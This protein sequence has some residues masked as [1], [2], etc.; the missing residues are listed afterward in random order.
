MSDV[1]DREVYET[2][3]LGLAAYLK[4]KDV[5]MKTFVRSGKKVVFVFY[6]DCKEK[7]CKKL[8]VEYLNSECK[9][10]D[11]FVRDFKKLFKKGVDHVCVS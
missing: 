10:F 7:D 6:D 9:K 11:S 3:I 4:M 8:Y 2:D 1:K 5:E